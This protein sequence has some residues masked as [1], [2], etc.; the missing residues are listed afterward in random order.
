MTLK[1]LGR[2]FLDTVYLIENNVR[3]RGYRYL[4]FSDDRDED[5]ICQKLYEGNQ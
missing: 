5:F 2:D 3:V 4:T 1:K